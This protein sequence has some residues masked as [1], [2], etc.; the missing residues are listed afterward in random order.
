MKSSNDSGEMGPV[1]LS[2]DG[3]PSVDKRV[4]K[5]LKPMSGLTVYRSWD[6]INAPSF[7]NDWLH[8]LDCDPDPHVFYHPVLVRS[9]C[10]TYRSFQDVSPLFCVAE[11]DGITVFLP[12][13]IWRRSWKNAFLRMI[14][15]VGFAEFDYHDPVVAGPRN[16]SIM[17]RFWAMVE[18]ELSGNPKIRYDTIDTSGWRFA[19]GEDGWEKSED[20]CPF[21][22]LNPYADFADYFSKISKSLRQDIGRQ[23]RRMAEAGELRFRVITAAE[24]ADALGMLP[25]FL[26]MHVKRWPNAFRAPGFHEAVL[27]NGVPAGIVHFSTL[28]LGSEPISW[29]LGFRYRNRYYYYLPVFL[30]QYAAY[31]PS[32]VHLSYLK[33]DCFAH[34][35]GIF[36]YLRGAESYK[37]GWASDVAPLYEFRKESASLQAL[38]KRGA[39]EG[40]QALKRLHAGN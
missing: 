27:R 29:H 30:E 36:D 33:E 5:K 6:E 32:K 26:E 12:L 18:R 8:W 20:V 2:C 7:V 4:E 22:D 25:R 21:V 11:I 9:W 39:F 40:I 28:Q 23:K 16:A 38:L 3:R 35:K 14:V 37:S 34:G 24:G 19:Y 10:D 13:V 31:S 15:P 1:D 17:K